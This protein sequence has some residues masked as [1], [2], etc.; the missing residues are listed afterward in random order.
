MD[1]LNVKNIN[2]EKIFNVID[3]NAQGEVVN[4]IR[5]ISISINQKAETI[6]NET[7]SV[8]N[9]AV[10][11]NDTWKSIL[12]LTF[13]DSLRQEYGKLVT[14]L[15]AIQKDIDM[16]QYKD[17]ETK[18]SDFLKYVANLSSKYTNIPETQNVAASKNEFIEITAHKNSFSA[19]VSDKLLGFMLRKFAKVANMDYTKA[20]ECFNV[21]GSNIDLYFHSPELFAKQAYMT[22]VKDN[23]VIGSYETTYDQFSKLA[24]KLT[25][26][27]QKLGY[28][29]DKMAGY[30]KTAEV[31][32]QNIFFD[33]VDE[34]KEWQEMVDEKK[35]EQPQETEGEE[36][37]T[38]E[39]KETEVVT[40]E[41]KSESPAKEEGGLVRPSE[42]F[43]SDEIPES[44]PRQQEQQQ[45]GQMA[46]SRRLNLLKKRALTKK[47]E[48]K[49]YK[50][51]ELSEEAKERARS[52]FSEDDR[53]W[54]YED[55]F[56]EE[57]EY[58]LKE[59][60]AQYNVELDNLDIEWD[61]Y[62]R[63]T[64]NLKDK[65]AYWDAFRTIWVDCAKQVLKDLPMFA[66]DAE[67]LED[68][69]TEAAS[70]MYFQH[71]HFEVYSGLNDIDDQDG[72]ELSYKISDL[73]TK[74][75]EEKVE[76]I[77]SEIAG[78]FEDILQKQEDYFYSEQYVKDECEQREILFDEDGNIEKEGKKSKSLRKNAN[79]KNLK[80]KKK[81]IEGDVQEQDIVPAKTE[82]KVY[83]QSEK[84]EDF[85]W[86]LDGSGFVEILA[87]KDLI[88]GATGSG[89]N[90]NGVNEL[91]D[92]I[93]KD[94]E[95]IPTEKIQK[96]VSGYG[97]ENV[98][99]MDRDELERYLVWL[100]AGDTADDLENRL[101]DEEEIKNIKAKA[102][103]K[104][105][106]SATD[107]KG[108][109]AELLNDINE[110]D[111]LVDYI[112]EDDAKKICKEL[113]IPHEASWYKGDLRGYIAEIP[114]GMV[115]VL[116]DYI[117]ES[118]A[119]HIWRQIQ[120]DLG[121]DIDSSKKTQVKKQAEETVE[122]KM[123]EQVG[124]DGDVKATIG[125]GDI[126]CI[127]FDSLSEGD[128]AKY[129]E[130]LGMPM[131]LI[132]NDKEDINKVI[133]EQV[134]YPF[135]RV[136]INK[137]N[138]GLFDNVKD[139]QVIVEDVD[140]NEMIT[141]FV[142]LPVVAKSCKIKSIHKAA[143]INRKAINKNAEK[144]E[145]QFWF[146]G[147]DLLID[148]KEEKC[149]GLIGIEVDYEEIEG[150]LPDGETSTG[151]TG[152]EVNDFKL[153]WLPNLTMES[154]P[155]REFTDEEREKIFKDNFDRFASFFDKEY[156]QT[157]MNTFPN[158]N[159]E[160]Y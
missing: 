34:A 17:A 88:L 72:T 115:D 33:S 53:S 128:F 38:V 4:R 47:A 32:M 2:D 11:W 92:Y 73:C 126:V 23:K 118:D 152:F 35:K 16:K 143:R 79:N 59:K 12:D 148:G 44:Q 99:E 21:K 136:T 74:A 60:Y 14:D 83:L 125:V 89:D 76:P 71:D 58:L 102:T 61:N 158:E 68:W 56:P 36:T 8:V 20:N 107:Y 27:P 120:H 85:A 6:N 64:V 103:N 138:I 66:N 95:K 63:C 132:E 159:E 134:E 109:V 122:E 156:I 97:I 49:L 84:A 41:G 24:S 154:N 93:K 30:I 117:S 81:A 9:L 87:P 52:A 104:M 124:E 144:D 110:P 82:T 77:L 70:D 142:E 145:K 129:S 119:E 150:V 43:A 5:P 146:E 151:E 31:V 114:D 29:R 26:T 54:W 1:S 7:D 100:L 25:L 155:Q 65:F 133:I 153:L 101:A 157:E 10:Y 57:Q 113:N 141:D 80:L 147:V 131:L 40:E 86:L 62:N 19:K 111:V 55:L 139:E 112:S 42:D 123:E 108:E 130:F 140:G 121:N 106:K 3:P 39:T 90:S 50:Y 105:K 78:D 45:G 127:N 91:R 135:Q 69:A 160:L 116:I 37:E 15:T 149:K 28:F 75:Y 137:D 13:N 94:L 22:V 48:E 18:T 67:L 51:E 96:I 98:K 46:A